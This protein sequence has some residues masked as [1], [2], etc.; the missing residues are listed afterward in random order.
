MFNWLFDSLM[1]MLG[2]IERAWDQKN[3]RKKR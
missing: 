1:T 3:R 2:F